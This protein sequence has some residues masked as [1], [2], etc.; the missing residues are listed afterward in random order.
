VMLRIDN[1][2]RDHEAHVYRKVANGV[3]LKYL[4]NNILDPLTE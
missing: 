3:S 2:E 4:V 1:G